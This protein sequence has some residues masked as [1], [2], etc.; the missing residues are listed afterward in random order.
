MLVDPDLPPQQTIYYSAASVL[1]VLRANASAKTDLATLFGVISRTGAVNS[2][3]SVILGLDFLYL[4]GLV[5]L[6]ADGDVV[7]S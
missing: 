6:D 1:G 5:Q 2:I 7:C 4:L 3:E